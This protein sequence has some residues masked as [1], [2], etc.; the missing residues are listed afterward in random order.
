[1]DAGSGFSRRVEK[2]P[3]GSV[4]DGV[5][6]SV[7]PLDADRAGAA[8]EGAYRT[9]L[10]RAPSPSA[11]SLLT[12]QWAHETDGGRAMHG[13]NFA[14]IKARSGGISLMT[15]EGSG[16]SA[17]FIR[18]RF[19][20]YPS[21]REGALDYVRL[22]ARRYPEA[23]G[24][25]DQGDLGRFVRALS[26]RGYFTAHPAEYLRGLG[27]RLGLASPAPHPPDAGLRR[28]FLA[29]IGALLSRR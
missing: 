7:T 16:Q 22:L 18:A 12:A 24:A 5:R 6:G 27:F 3:F 1:M 4:S 9:V 2:T 17:T 13:H 23:L 10:G 19:R 20:G 11:L 25:A 28:G 26:R 14:G 8:I 29:A 15:R 21:V